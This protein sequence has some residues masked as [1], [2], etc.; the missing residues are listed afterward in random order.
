[1]ITHRPAT[2]APATHIAVMEHGRLVDFGERDAVLH[3]LNAG[4]PV[5]PIDTDRSVEAA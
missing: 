3:R 4:I 1:M 2:L 5:R